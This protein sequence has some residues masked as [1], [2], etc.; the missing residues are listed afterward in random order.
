MIHCM[1]CRIIC[2]S[3]YFY[4]PRSTYLLGTDRA[5]CFAEQ[6]KLHHG[7]YPWKGGLNTNPF[8][9]SVA[10]GHRKPIF[11]I[12]QGDNP[13]RLLKKH[14]Y[15]S[16]SHSNLFGG[17]GG[18]AFKKSL[19]VDRLQNRC[20]YWRTWVSVCEEWRQLVKD[21]HANLSLHV[22]ISIPHGTSWW[23]IYIYIFMISYVCLAL[24]AAHDPPN[25]HTYTIVHLNTCTMHK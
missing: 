20:I 13:Q 11:Q 1:I 2:P 6:D 16:Q 22:Q 24:I 12:Q 8:R 21:L 17:D 15:C 9:N 7:H 19:P 4:I 3:F 18:G 10:H 25:M 14:L 5:K 23:Y